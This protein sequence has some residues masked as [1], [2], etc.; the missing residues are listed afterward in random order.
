MTG[1]ELAWFPAS[2][3]VARASWSKPLPFA[4]W[5]HAVTLADVIE[6]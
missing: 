6:P 2:Q 5:R 4:S 1:T 3:A